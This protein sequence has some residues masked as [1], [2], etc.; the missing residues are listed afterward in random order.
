MF[1]THTNIDKKNP[2]VC[3]YDTVLILYSQFGYNNVFSVV[4]YKKG[5]TKNG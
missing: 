2:S 3:C 1:K 4:F 5:K